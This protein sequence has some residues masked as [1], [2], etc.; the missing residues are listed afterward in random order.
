MHLFYTVGPYNGI[1]GR[2]S[3]DALRRTLVI[4]FFLVSY[5]SDD[6][7][8]PVIGIC[9]CLTQNVAFLH[10]ICGDTRLLYFLDENPRWNLGPTGPQLR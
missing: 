3:H 4:W 8:S 2:L 5:V 6:W 1:V 7:L 9:L 10:L